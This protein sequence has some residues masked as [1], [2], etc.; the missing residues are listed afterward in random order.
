MNLINTII[1]GFKEIWAHKFR[2]LL[3]MLGIILGVASLVAMAALTKGMENGMKETMVAMGGADKVLIDE[4]DVPPEQE[5]LANE[6]PGRTMHDVMALRQGAPLVRLVSPEMQIRGVLSHGGKTVMPSELV[7]AW[8]EVL[9]MNL[10][11]IQY[12]R[13]FYRSRRRKRQQRHCHWHRHSR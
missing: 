5:H 11:T 13:F 12:G 8:P 4:N 9:E 3:T 1:V 2:S 10:H 7:G 6:A